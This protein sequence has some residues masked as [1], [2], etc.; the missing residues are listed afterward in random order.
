MKKSEEDP[1]RILNQAT[2]LAFLG[3]QSI[4]PVLHEKERL[5][6]E[7]RALRKEN[8][9]LKTES[10]KKDQALKTLQRKCT[11]L[12]HQLSRHS[13]HESINQYNILH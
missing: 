11:E 2:G 1:K 13:K 9:R 12:E 7:G 3:V 4:I 6:D 5:R 8:T 10:Q